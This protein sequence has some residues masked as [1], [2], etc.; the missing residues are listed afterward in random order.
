MVACDQA[1]WLIDHVGKPPHGPA[2][3]VW[4]AKAM[5]AFPDLEVTTCHHYQIHAP[6]QWQCLNA[7]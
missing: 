5:A 4:A 7:A 6:F 2:F 1:T 3:K